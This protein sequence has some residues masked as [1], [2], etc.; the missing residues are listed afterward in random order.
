M[1]RVLVVLLL[2]AGISAGWGQSFGSDLFDFLPPDISGWGDDDASVSAMMALMKMDGKIPL[3]FLNA[4][5]GKSLTG[6]QI[7]ITGVGTFITD[8]YGIISIPNKQ[9]DGTYTLTCSK[10]GFITT[11]IN[12]RIVQNLV[13]NDWFSISPA[14][15]GDFR[16]VLEW[17]ERP[18]DL[19]LHFEK[20]GGYHISYRTMKTAA[21]GSA[22]LDRD[23]TSSWGPETITIKKADQRSGYT[24]YVIDY[25]NS[26][27]RSSTALSQSGARVR[28]YGDNKLLNTF[29]VP[30]SGQGT[31]WNVLRIENNTIVPVNTI[32]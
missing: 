21:D 30:G 20:S 2:C 1:K 24:L 13:I 32:Q 17:G 12:F 27:S 7:A 3:R 15:N 11:P 9:R 8:N 26:G 6:A 31:R 16:I 25:T 4:V 28:V 14:L 29:T 10:T 5:D 19:D 22:Q 23:D 18:F